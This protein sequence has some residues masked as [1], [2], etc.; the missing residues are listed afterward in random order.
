M[1][2]LF[3]PTLCSAEFRI[4]DITP[5]NQIPFEEISIEELVSAETLYVEEIELEK[6][7]SQVGAILE[8]TPH[9]LG[10][11]CVGYAR[12]KKAL[13]QPLYSLSDKTS[14][15]NSSE[16]VVGAVAITAESWYGHL[17]IVVE[18][19]EDT[20]VIEEGNYITGYKTV[21]VVDKD[22]PIGYYL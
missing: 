4:V 14:I 13:P 12:A 6:R 22:F 19:K 16:P 18:I 17:S 8:A 11:N 21:R 20:I 2:V 7:K 10:N 15:I 9:R 5:S 3:I 1:L